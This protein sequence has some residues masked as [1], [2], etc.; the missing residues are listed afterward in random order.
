MNNLY[1]NG[2]DLW[3][4]FNCGILKGIQYP[5]VKEIIENIHGTQTSVAHIWREA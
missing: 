5:V 2:K 3:N 1:F 4:D